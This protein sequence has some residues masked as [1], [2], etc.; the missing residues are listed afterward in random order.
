MKKEKRNTYR[1]GQRT[2]RLA[3]CGIQEIQSFSRKPRN[4]R[5]QAQLSETKTETCELL[6]KREKK[7]RGARAGVTVIA[8][9][10]PIC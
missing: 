1:C 2:V 4:L 3:G 9:C 7:N 10:K 5:A 6:V 8:S